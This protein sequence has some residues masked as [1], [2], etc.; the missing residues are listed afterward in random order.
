MESDID[1]TH[2]VFSD[3]AIWCTTLV[4]ASVMTAT[5]VEKKQTGKSEMEKGQESGGRGRENVEVNGTYTR[6]FKVSAFGSNSDMYS[7][8]AT[9]ETRLNFD[10]TRS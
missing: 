6:H 5:L 1:G 3:E 7:T 10:S 9:S 8:S 4:M 2:L